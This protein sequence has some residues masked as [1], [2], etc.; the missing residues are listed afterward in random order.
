V[1][2]NNYIDLIKNY[3]NLNS[4]RFAPK[5]KIAESPKCIFDVTAIKCYNFI[6]LSRQI[7][8]S[9]KPPQT[10]PQEQPKNHPDAHEIAPRENPS[11]PR[12]WGWINKLAAGTAA[13][14]ALLLAACNKDTSTENSQHTPDSGE[15]PSSSANIRENKGEAKKAKADAGTEEKKPITTIKEIDGDPKKLAE[16]I[17]H[18]KK[19]RTLGMTGVLS[20]PGLMF[21]D[22][23]RT[24][25]AAKF[26][27]DHFFPLAEGKFNN[28]A[29]PALE[30][31]KF[32]DG[33][34]EEKDL[35]NL[36]KVNPL[37]EGIEN[38]KQYPLFV[39]NGKL[40]PE[41]EAK[42]KELYGEH[43]SL[44]VVPLIQKYTLDRK[45]YSV[46][47]LWVNIEGDKSKLKRKGFINIT[48]LAPVKDETRQKAP[49]VWTAV[50]S[51]TTAHPITDK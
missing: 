17:E 46:V 40:N 37:T 20:M 33:K 15:V 5:S 38:Q 8:Q 26:A 48:P 39:E 51:M 31:F 30:L 22:P 12:R 4:N 25:K 41:L 13:A 34:L 16:Y 24:V 14:V 19:N 7:Q 11:Q 44:K 3:T 29:Y 49:V 23:S 45:I 6:L 18:F 47:Y 21:T 50:E 36:F 42:I 10:P 2:G 1:A 28:K 43:V 9:M 32:F 27:N 35:P